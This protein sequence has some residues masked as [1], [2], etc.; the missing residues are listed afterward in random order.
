MQ[1]Y[2]LD[3][4]ISSLRSPL[5]PRVLET[6]FHQGKSGPPVPVFQA[7]RASGSDVAVSLARAAFAPHSLE[8]PGRRRREQMPAA[9]TSP[10]MWLLSARVAVEPE[11]LVL[12]NDSEACGSAATG[13]QQSLREQWRGRLW[14]V[15]LLCK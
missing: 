9:A 15:A 13:S 7:G 6:S 1:C 11:R 14:A 12:G 8:A 2:P 4:G 3:K 5:G 10:T